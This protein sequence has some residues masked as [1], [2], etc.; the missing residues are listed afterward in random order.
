MAGG[1]LYDE[2]KVSF[3]ALGAVPRGNRNEALRPDFILVD[4][5]DTDETQ[6]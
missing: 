3:M 2:G 1:T 5:I 6:P 4:D